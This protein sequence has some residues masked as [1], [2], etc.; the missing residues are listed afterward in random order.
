MNV[1][2]YGARRLRP[3]TTK[4]AFSYPPPVSAQRSKCG[5]RSLSRQLLKSLPTAAVPYPAALRSCWSVRSWS[6]RPTA[7]C[8]VTPWLWV[9]R[10]LSRDARLGQQLGV[11]ATAFGK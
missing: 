11:V 10:P 3:S 8:W 9:N 4:R 5:G 7:S 2:E 1:V 6:Y